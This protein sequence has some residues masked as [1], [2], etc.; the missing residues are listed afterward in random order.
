ML[1]NTETDHV[2][3]TCIQRLGVIMTVAMRSS[4]TWLLAWLTQTLFFKAL[5][6]I[7]CSPPTYSI[8][9][10]SDKSSQVLATF[11]NHESPYIPSEQFPPYKEYLHPTIRQNCQDRRQSFLNRMKT[12]QQASDVWRDG[13]S[14][15]QATVTSL[16]NTHYS[17]CKTTQDWTSKLQVT[18]PKLKL[19]RGQ[20]W[21]RWQ[22]GENWHINYNLTN[23]ALINCCFY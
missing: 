13:R 20:Y 9:S 16:E 1:H 6:A 12:L 3:F 7:F 23:S 18:P 21:I 8:W 10:D 4:C 22:P 17:T 14:D 5:S 19:M 11:R 15:N 2:G